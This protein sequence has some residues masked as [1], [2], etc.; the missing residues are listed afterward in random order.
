M[1]PGISQDVK[2]QDDQDFYRGILTPL[3]AETWAL[4]QDQDWDPDLLFHLFVEDIKLTQD[5]FDTVVHATATL[6]REHAGV[7]GVTSACSD[8]ARTNAAIAGLGGCAPDTYLVNGQPLLK[9]MND[10]GDHC[11]QFQYDALT[12]VADDPGLPYRRR[13]VEIRRRPSH[14]RDR[15][16]GHAVAV[17]AERL[18]RRDHGLGRHLSS[19]RPCPKSFAVVL[20]QHALP[21]E[22]RAIALAATSEIGSQ[23][24]AMSNEDKAYIAAHGVPRGC[25]HSASLQIGITTRSPDGMLYY[26]GEVARAQLPLDPTRTSNTVMLR[27]DDGKQT[28]LLLLT[29]GDMDDPAV[30]VTYRGET[31]SVPHRATT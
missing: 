14:G 10:P 3:S 11:R 26:M 12:Q 15:V 22:R 5:D 2:P 1:T 23:I 18:E 13:D 6:C 19:S 9:L 17:R 28:A 29:R 30:R 4:Y 7:S 21:R 27:G 31:Y 16:Q 25:E 24:R 8:L 20:K